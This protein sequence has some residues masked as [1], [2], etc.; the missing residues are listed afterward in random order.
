VVRQR[1]ARRSLASIPGPSP[2]PGSEL[3]VAGSEQVP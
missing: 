2:I 1:Q 3:A